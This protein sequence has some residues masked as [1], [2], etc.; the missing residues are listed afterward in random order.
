MASMSQGV[1]FETLW[2]VKME[3][4]GGQGVHGMEYGLVFELNLYVELVSN[5]SSLGM[6]GDHL[7]AACSTG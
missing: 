7:A 4:S 6:R 3:L 5:L 2:C 1:T